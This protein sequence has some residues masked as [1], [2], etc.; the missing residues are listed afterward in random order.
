MR[1]AR[2]FALT[3]FDA[4]LARLAGCQPAFRKKIIDAYAATVL[5]DEHVSV[6]EAELLR[7]VC[8]A[9]DC[10]APP[11]ARYASAPSAA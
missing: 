10:P 4:T 11:L 3:E 2:I 9:L 6:T 1:A 7:V 8:R 5:H